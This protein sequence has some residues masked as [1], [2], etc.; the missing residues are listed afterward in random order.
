MA[1]VRARTGVTDPPSLSRRALSL[2]LLDHRVR[3]VVVDGLEIL[4]L[5]AVPLD[6]LVAVELHGNVAHHVLD[7]LRVVV[8]ALGDELLVR[9]LEQPVELARSVLLGIV[10]QLLDPHEALGARRDGDVR[11]LVVRAVVGD[12]LRARAQARH[13]DDD[14]HLEALLA[15][16][17]LADESHLVVHQALDLRDGRGLVDEIR[18]L[19]LDVARLSLEPLD[20][21]VEHVLERFDRDLALVRVEDL[22]EARHVRALELVREADVHVEHRDGAL[23]A[24]RALRDLDRMADRLDTDLVDGELAPVLGLLDVGN[25]KRVTDIHGE[26]FAG[27]A[28]YW[29][30]L[31]CAPFPPFRSAGWELN[32]SA[33]ESRRRCRRN[34]PRP[35]RA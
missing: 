5:H 19:H 15:L 20:H 30:I 8:R 1:S 28:R 31:T 14:L 25:G 24:A 23:G 35:R 11:A 17:D 13:R 18:E 3:R 32:P 2:V 4:R 29:T 26:P 22:D 34:P 16:A 6:A 10:D 9:T 12:P 27:M 7:E 33:R 21:L